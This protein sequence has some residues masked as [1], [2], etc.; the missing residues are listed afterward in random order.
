M[1]FIWQ[2]IGLASAKYPEVAFAR[3]LYA[4]CPGLWLGSALGVSAWAA[5][6][7]M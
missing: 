1:Q 5:P 3:P 2:E 6:L 7:G 4:T